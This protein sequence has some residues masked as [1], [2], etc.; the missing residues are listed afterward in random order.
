MTGDLLMQRSAVI[1]RDER[2]RYRLDRKWG[3]AGKPVVWI[4]LNPST[5]DGEVDDPTIRRCMAFT[6]RWGHQWMIVVN[7]FA[8]RATNPDD[9]R[10]RPDPVGPLNR[11]HVE[12][13]CRLA[14]PPRYE[15]GD[16]KVVCAWGQHGAYMGQGDTVLGWLDEWG[17]APLCLGR[18]AAGT[19]RHP[20]Y[21]HGATNPERL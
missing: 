10:R 3:Y 11:E 12:E 6:Q 19:P 13:A 1:S 8:L 21:I 9:L 20:L 16:G 4:M 15:R 2:Y 17:V 5:A 14:F 7:L 18:T